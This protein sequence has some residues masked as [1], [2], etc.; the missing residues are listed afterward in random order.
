LA[1]KDDSNRNNKKQLKLNSM[2]DA[3]YELFVTKGVNETA[4][5]DIVKKAGVAK[6][7]FYL[8]F[9]DKYDITDQIVLGESTLILKEAM[10]ATMKEGIDNFIDATI[11]FIDHVIEHFK[12]NKKQLKLMYKN[13]SWGLYRKA[14][15]DPN[16]YTEM[17][18]LAELVFNNIE[19]SGV[20]REEL[21]KTMFMVI[22]LTGSVAY[23]SII[24]EEPAPIDEM[25]PIL[26]KT[27]RKMLG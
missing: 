14:I 20:K 27:I 12:N 22:E 8:Y 5:D 3:A 10:H 4:I 23:S 11:F 18:E 17:R 1:T 7:T 19:G 26:F 16:N 2:F 25:K 15:A 21:D 6:G 13:L 9:K 24:L